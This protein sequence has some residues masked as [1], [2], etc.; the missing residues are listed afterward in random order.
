MGTG[1]LRAGSPFS[2]ES[3]GIPHTSRP[4]AELTNP[5]EIWAQR[6][7][8]GSVCLAKSQVRPGLGLGLWG[9]AEGLL[10]THVLQLQSL[11]VPL[12]QLTYHLPYVQAKVFKVSS[13]VSP[14]SHL[15]LMLWSLTFLLFSTGLGLEASLLAAL[16]VHL[17]L[18]S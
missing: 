17:H 13:Q 2:L 7:S 3:S 14:Q 12:N 18:Y 4:G 5:S 11:S 6:E 9:C 10:I 15:L 8:R 16:Q 1:G